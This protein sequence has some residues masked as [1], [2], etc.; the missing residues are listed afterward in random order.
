MFFWDKKLI[1]H[2]YKNSVNNNL[3]WQ[4]T[5][6]ANYEVTLAYYKVTLANYKLALVTSSHEKV[7]RVNNLAMNKASQLK[8]KFSKLSD[9]IG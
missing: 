5:N 8:S 3:H 7:L 4:I 1:H 9:V 6:S 2:V